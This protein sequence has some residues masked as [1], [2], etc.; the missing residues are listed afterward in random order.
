[1]TV[2]SRGK[3]P[4]LDNGSFSLTYTRNADSVA[5]SVQV[6]F[7]HILYI[8]P[9]CRQQSY[10]GLVMRATNSVVRRK[11][12]LTSQATS[13]NAVSFGLFILSYFMFG[14]N[15]FCTRLLMPDTVI[16]ISKM[17][18]CSKRKREKIG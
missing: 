6:C 10:T 16:S 14:I 18:A 11:V 1:M 17:H 9:N 4:T 8:H 2:Q 5:V 13:L 3:G 12:G 7:S 15:S